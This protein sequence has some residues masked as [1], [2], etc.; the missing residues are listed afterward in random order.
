MRLISLFAAL[1]GASCFIALAAAHHLASDAAFP[2]VVLAALAQIGA[3]AGGLAIANRN[4]KLNL[5]GGA[6]ILV[7]AN[8]FA[9]AL[10]LP[11]FTTSNALLPLTPIGGGVLII[12][13]LVLA[14]AKP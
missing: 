6:L 10:Y 13:W 3:A 9:T 2:H 11:V 12:G 14:L 7:G 8:L 4:G 5:I 1:T